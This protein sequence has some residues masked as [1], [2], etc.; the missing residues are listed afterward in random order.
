MESVV[1]PNLLTSTSPRLPQARRAAELP[2]THI[3]VLLPQSGPPPGGSFYFAGPFCR[4]APPM[5]KSRLDVVLAERGLFESRTR[6]AAAIMAG[7]VLLGG[8]GARAEKPGQMVTDDVE[9]AV[10]GGP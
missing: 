1:S 9:V 10:E 5:R 7:Q 8:G 4:Y 6:A 3:A 2:L